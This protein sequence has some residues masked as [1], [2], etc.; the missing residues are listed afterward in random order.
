MNTNKNQPNAIEKA[1]DILSAF[2]P[3][4][5]EMGTQQIS[6][7][8]GLHKATASRIL[9][10]LTRKGYLRQNPENK[11][12]RLDRRALDLG[13]AVM[14]S[15]HDNL[16]MIAKPHIDRLRELLNETVTF[17]YLFGETT[18]MLYIAEGQR[19]HRI[20]GDVGDR[21][22]I[23]ATACAKAILAFS[24]PDVV[25]SLLGDELEFQT[26]TPNTITTI[27]QLHAQLAEARRLGYAY[28]NEEIDIGISAIGFPVF[29]HT[30]TP[31]AALAIVGPS[32]RI[33][34]VEN[35]DIVNLGHQ[36]ARKISA[37]LLQP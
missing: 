22:P 9:L 6:T 11:K 4:N 35:K 18:I 10:I 8:L 37:L 23:H 29:D 25:E 28:D 34:P 3:H 17:E 32:H 21:L 33:D 20:A 30:D 15:L 36:T 12:F 5:P 13:R 2:T 19:R 31:V 16:V 24:E 14:N 7:K 1:L 26:M 27:D